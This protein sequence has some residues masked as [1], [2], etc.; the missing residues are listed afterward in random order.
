MSFNIASA[1]LPV[2]TAPTGAIPRSPGSTS[3]ATAAPVDLPLNSGS[4][5]SDLGLQFN[6]LLTIAANALTYGGL[7]PGIVGSY[8][9][10]GQLSLYAE[11][12]STSAYVPG[13][14]VSYSGQN[15]VCI[16]NSTGNL[17]TNATYFSTTSTG[18]V[19][20]GL[21][22]GIL[23]GTGYAY[24]QLDFA[25]SVEVCGYST[26]S[27]VYVWLQQSPWNPSTANAGT[28]QMTNS[29][30]P[31]AGAP[32]LLLGTFPTSAGVIGQIDYSGVC[33][34]SPGMAIRYTADRSA[35][36][37]SPSAATVFHTIVQ[38][39]N[40][41]HFVWNGSD[42]FNLNPTSTAQSFNLTLTG[43]LQLLPQDNGFKANL[44]ASGGNQTVLLPDPATL[45]DGWTI[46]LYNVGGS[47]S[48]VL[49]DHTG[50][51]T[52]ATLTT[53]NKTLGVTA[54]YNGTSV[55]FPGGSWTPGPVPTPS[56]AS[57]Y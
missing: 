35:P 45:A 34:L 18:S 8:S 47:N 22:V 12:N 16:L 17:P 27:Y 19:V 13:N 40:G 51:T 15:Y 30:T 53:T 36:T 20:T 41:P 43:T 3:M 42:Y 1:N 2:P 32:S 24:G 10:Q 57:A 49:K 31:P 54:Y 11:Y 6:E 21:Q 37:D 29:T 5:A 4:I 46:L 23:P 56:A 9:V 39:G 7:V 25:G 50:V 28:I 26:A 33:Y 48:I 55:V 14:I 44:V 38:G 52:L